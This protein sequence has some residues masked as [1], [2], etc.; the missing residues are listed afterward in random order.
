M[1]DVVNRHNGAL[2]LGIWTVEI[3]TELVVCA[4][5]AGHYALVPGVSIT[6]IGV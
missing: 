1:A 2:E 4:Y 6:Q 5:Y 3:T